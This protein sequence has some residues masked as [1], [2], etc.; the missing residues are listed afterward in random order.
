MNWTGLDS[1]LNIYSEIQVS[2]TQSFD[3]ESKKKHKSAIIYQRQE[4]SIYRSGYNPTPINQGN[5][6]LQT[7]RRPRRPR[8]S[9][10][11][12][13]RIEVERKKPAKV[14]S[15]IFLKSP[16]ECREEIAFRELLNF[17]FFTRSFILFARVVRRRSD[18]R[19]V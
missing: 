5:K 7:P 10:R 17:Q 2:R 9:H 14:S 12:R 16:V 13:R 19:S 11:L 18:R 1:L 3:E 4:V 8:R 6:T 15:I